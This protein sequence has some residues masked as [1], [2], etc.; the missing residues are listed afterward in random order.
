MIK[1]LLNTIKCSLLIV[2]AAFTSCTGWFD[3]VPPYEAT[4][5]MLK[6]DN[7]KVGAFFPQLQRNVI[8]THNNQFQ[9][10]E[11]L[12]GDIF[13]GYMATP[14]PF[15]SNK[16]NGT[17][18]F[19]D[20]WLNHPFE[21]V[22]AQAMGA[23]EEIR[24]NL[25]SDEDSHIYQW[26]KILRVAS[27]HRFTDMWGPIP[28]SK[29]GDGSMSAPYDSQEEVYKMFFQELDMAIEVLTKF[30]NENPT[31]KPMKDYDLVYGGDYKK[32]IKFANSLKLRLAMRCA[33]VAPE[34]ARKNAEEAV[35]NGVIEANTDNAGVKSVGANIVI[36][37][38]YTMWA[39]YQDIRMGASIQSIMSGYKDP[40]LPKMFREATVEGQTGY[41]G[42]RT[43]INISNKSEHVDF[44]TPNIQETDPV[45]WMT[46][47]EVEFLK[48]EGALRGWN[49]GVSAKDA[50]EKAIRLSFE[51]WGVSDAVSSYLGDAVSMPTKYI[52]PR[53]PS[54]DI[55]P[56][57]SITIA[58]NDEDSDEKKLERIITQKWIAMFPNGQEG[59]SEYRRTGYPKIF[60]V[61]LNYSA[62]TI[63]TQE[64]IR[65][66]P[67]PKSEYTLNLENITKAV[68][69]LNGPDNGG[70]KLWWDAKK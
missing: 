61:E 43:G 44:S 65:R 12:V 16:H 11:N 37:Q 62:G 26:A 7:V 22:Y 3:N 34:L 52:N 30:V 66:Y 6:G 41:F 32:W 49:M 13:S 24:K 55:D 20:G 53:N 42:V 9:M 8:S 5:D 29:V 4:E 25:D 56:V 38:L 60:P 36:N 45:L 46:A 39:N 50:Y 15:N 68:Q 57:S 40:R 18:F 63:D 48:A 27:M 35:T 21:K 2:M 1:N 58:W 31:S 64:Q 19:Q 51:Q 67:F 54:E 70:T 23:F 33:Y 28:Y 14:T 17:Y 69:L 59:W 47:S 10:S